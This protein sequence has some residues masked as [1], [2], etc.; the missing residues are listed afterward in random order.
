MKFE[1]L[2]ERFNSK[3][4]TL[5]TIKD[6]YSCKERVD[7]IGKCGHQ[8][9]ASINNFTHS[10]S[11]VYCKKCSDENRRNIQSKQGSSARELEYEGFLYLKEILEPHFDI[12]KTN[13]GCI[14]DLCIRPKS[15][16]NEWL[17]IQT[18]T[19]K[20][21]YKTAYCFQINKNVY[22][23]CVIMCLAIDTKKIWIF[24]SQEVNGKVK[25]T[26]S[27]KK[28]GLHTEEILQ[29]LNE[30]YKTTRLFSSDDVLIP[31]SIYQKREHEYRIKREKMFPEITFEYPT[32]EGQKYD[33][34][35]NGYKFQEKVA[36][37]RTGREEYYVSHMYSP[38]RTKKKYNTYKKGDCDFYWI[39]LD[40]TDRFFVIPEDAMIE[41]NIVETE[42]E[43]PTLHIHEN[44]WVR[45]FESGSHFVTY[46]DF[47]AFL[48]DTRTNL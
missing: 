31:Q 8:S 39:W 25:Q 34:I 6:D 24:D 43:R 30:Y 33:F 36:G 21:P 7:F 1:T 45:K 18:K 37:K 29:K 5:T 42:R 20:K 44:S 26:V 10:D 12:I 2:N 41:H 14:S 40:K 16:T 17:Q 47:G 23:D 19:T 38:N 4:C 35:V 48:S 28:D 46:Q 27:I 13:E 11:G 32:I 3:G 9:N 15:T 22:N